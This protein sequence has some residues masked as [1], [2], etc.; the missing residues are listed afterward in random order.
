[1]SKGFIRL[2]RDLAQGE[3]WR[4]LSANARALLIDIWGWYNG[5]NNGRIRYSIQQAQDALR[6]SRMTAIRT[7]AELRTAGMI[8]ETERG[9]FRYKVGARI[10]VSSSWRIT[11]LPDAPA[12]GSK[13]K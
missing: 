13:S 6:C 11:L 2:D 10:G 1:M 12:P 4:S 9:G 8:E 3:R 7:L 5:H